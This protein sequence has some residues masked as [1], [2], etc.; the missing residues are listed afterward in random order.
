[1]SNA[2]EQQLRSQLELE[3]QSKQDALKTA[4][5]DQ[6]TAEGLLSKGTQIVVALTAEVEALK[7]KLS[8]FDEVF[9]TASPEPKAAGRKPKKAKP[10]V[11]N[12][13]RAAQGRREVADGKR[14]KI[15]EAMREVMGTEV[16]NA[17]QIHDLLE[18]RGWLPNS[19]SPLHY[20]RYLLSSLADFV[21]VEGR[22]RGLYA[23]V[24]STPQLVEPSAAQSNGVPLL[25]ETDEILRDAGVLPAN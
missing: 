18:E 7:I 9:G 23:V 16:M 12:N 20:I 22:S 17:Q 1:M 13:S 14:P 15:R 11:V 8:K 24:T 4:Q 21:R 2:I 5:A 19:T 6:R 10:A 25:S 3:L